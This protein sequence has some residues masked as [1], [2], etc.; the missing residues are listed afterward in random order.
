[1]VLADPSSVDGAARRQAGRHQDRR[2][3]RP[4]ARPVPPHHPQARHQAD[5]GGR[6]RRQRR[7]SSP[8]AATRAAP[9]SPR[10]WPP[11]STASTS[12]PRTSRTRPTT[13]PASWCW[14]ARPTG[15]AQGSGP[16]VT[17]FV[18]RV[19]NL[20]AALYKALGGF[21][22]NGVNMTKLESYMVDGN[23]FAT[24]ILCRCRWPSRRQ[25]PRLRAGGAEILLARIPHRRRLSRPIPSARRSAKRRSELSSTPPPAG[26]ART[27]PPAGCRTSC[28]PRGR[29][30]R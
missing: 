11:R 19:R 29:R 17:T 28:A 21:A 15:P 16:L 14:R 27:H 9:R 26:R 20:P 4:R 23:F 12:W 2:K 18:F 30:P 25:E 24:A 1:M 8:N 22:T 6:Y 7:A 13:P 5:R 3:P 10:S